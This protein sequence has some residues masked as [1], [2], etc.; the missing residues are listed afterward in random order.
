MAVRND[1]QLPLS[2][3]AV[4][5]AENAARNEMLPIPADHLKWLQRITQNRTTCLERDTDLPTLAHF[6]DN[7][8]V[9][10]CRNGSDWCDVHPLLREVVDT[11][12]TPPVA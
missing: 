5:P 8:L 9:L 10:N 2:L 7:R 4:V 1:D 6:L 12:G 11:H 3:Q